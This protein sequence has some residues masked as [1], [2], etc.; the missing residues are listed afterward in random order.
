MVEIE[1]RKR[2]GRIALGMVVAGVAVAGLAYWLGVRTVAGQRAEDRIVADAQALH[3]IT[4]TRPEVLP[5][6]A[7]PMVVLAVLALVVVG[8]AR[9]RLAAALVAIMLL[10]A[11][12]GAGALLKALLPR[13][14]LNLDG[15]ATANSFPSGHVVLAMSIVLALLVVT[16]AALRLLVAGVG[17]VATSLVASATLIAAW[18]RPS[19]VVGAVAVCVV[20]F[21]VATTVADRRGRLGASPAGVVA[22]VFGGVGCL[23]VSVVGTMLFQLPAAGS[24]STELLVA[25]AGVDLA[26]VAGVVCAVL[27]LRSTGRGARVRVPVLALARTAF[28]QGRTARSSGHQG[29][30]RQVMDGQRDSVWSRSMCASFSGLRTA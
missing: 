23:V 7:V 16:P 18:H 27:F 15:W 25:C 3:A 12:A 13:P 14:R 5:L 24:R 20:L 9:R 21:V 17:A 22:T 11:G 2:Q 28:T 4:G 29:A 19:D 10:S 26:V 1:D 30:W 6:P 8:L